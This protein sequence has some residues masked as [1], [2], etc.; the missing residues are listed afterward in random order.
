MAVV[1]KI[2]TQLAEEQAQ[3]H[4]VTTQRGVTACGFD[5]STMLNTSQSD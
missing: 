5:F 2:K 4:R 3:L 1:M